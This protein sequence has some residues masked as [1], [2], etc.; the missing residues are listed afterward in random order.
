MSQSTTDTTDG[1]VRA[2]PL[3]D[4]IDAGHK[5]VQLNGHTIALFWHQEKPYAVDNRCPHM[6][7]PLDQGSV[8]DCILTCHWHHARFDLRTGGTF[9]LWADDGR[10][11]RTRIDR[12]DVWVQIKE[13]SDTIKYRSG[14]LDAG[15]AHDLSLVICKSVIGLLDEGVSPT[16]PL[17]QGLAFGSHYRREGWGQGLT[18]LTCMTNLLPVMKTDDRPRAMYHG[19]S[20]LA[21]ECAGS[22]PRFCVTPLPQS[23][24]SAEQY[25]RWFRQFVEVRDAQGSER[26]LITAF[27][28]GVSRNQIADMLFTAATDHRYIEG[29]HIADFTNKAL[30]ALDHVDWHDA[31]NILGSLAHGYASAARMEESNAWRHPIDLVSMLEEAF[32]QLSE[33]LGAG[34]AFRGSWTAS[35]T[36]I[37]T[38]LADDPEAIIKVLLE[39]LRSG[40]TE[41]QLAERVSYAAVRR[42]AHFHISNEFTDWDTALHTFT[43]ANAI[44]QGL[45]RAPSLELLRGV[46]DAAMSIY[47]DRFLNVPS[48]PLPKK[49]SE[50]RTAADLLMDLESL[51]DQ[52]QKVNEAGQVVAAYFHADGEPGELLATLV[53]LLLREDRDF[54]TIQMVE[55]ACQQF[56]SLTDAQERIHVLVAAARYLAAHAPT[57]RSQQQTYQIAL[58]LHRG[59]A[60]YK[61]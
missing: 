7:F 37:D 28:S 41:V 3:A 51:L 20:A 4:L 24:A 52:Q 54:H 47:L 48:T 60:I 39:S 38:L 61:A 17:S 32:E 16:G 18:I 29:G 11:Y 49:K 19:L 6:G 27:K 45:V 30:E 59:E 40:A 23:D 53:R 36:L 15:L 5:V 46:F 25:K 1:F 33:T 9:D 57:S 21:L 35:D 26:C 2:L 14:R 58:R 13:D 31:T 56:G 10:A 12:D 44:Q 42:V 50:S 8:D 43:F 22:V 55:A 34:I